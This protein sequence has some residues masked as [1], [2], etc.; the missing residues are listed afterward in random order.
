[1]P[2]AERRFKA[3]I[4]QELGKGATIPI[5]AASIWRAVETAG[6]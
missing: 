3:M 4:P 2:A 5:F 1:M 6:E